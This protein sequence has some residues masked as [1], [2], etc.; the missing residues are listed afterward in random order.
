MEES[1]HGVVWCGVEEKKR[2]EWEEGGKENSFS[3]L[4]K[5]T[6]SVDGGGSNSSNGSRGGRNGNGPAPEP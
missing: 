2:V 3:L 5:R 6:E 4:N 1:W